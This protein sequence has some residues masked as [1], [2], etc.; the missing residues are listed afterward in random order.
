MIAVEDYRYHITIRIVLPG[1]TS[2][3]TVGIS[4]KGFYSNIK[5]VIIKK[6]FKLGLLRCR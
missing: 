6:D 1:K 2:D 3:Y 5:I 4:V